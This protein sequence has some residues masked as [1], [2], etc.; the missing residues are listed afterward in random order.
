MN[1][2]STLLQSRTAILLFGL[3]A[4]GFGCHKSGGSDTPPTV[5][6]N[7]P[8]D[9]ATDVPINGRVSA[10]FSQEMD[11]ATLDG[12]TFT[13]T[14]GP[15]ANPVVGTVIYADSTATFWPSVHLDP[16]GSYDASITTGAEN[17]S[18]TPIQVL[19][20]WHFQ[21]GNT[22]EPG[23]PVPL[24]T[25]IN[26][27]ILAKSGI[28][29]VPNSNIT[30]DI[31]VSPAAATLITG[32]SLIMDASNTFSTSTQVTGEVRAADYSPPTPAV[33]TTA[34]SNM[35][36]AFTDAAGRAPDFTEL[37]AGD[38]GGLILPPGVYKWGTGVLIPTDVTLNGSATD[39][40][41][42]QIAQDLTMAND[43]Q[44]LLTGG[45]LPEN[46]F[47]QVTG[48]VDLGTTTQLN[49]IILCAT[50]INLQTNAAVNGRLMAQTA[51]TTDQCTVVAP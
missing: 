18:G 25:A 42:L 3:A 50:S 40:W 9:Q 22:T 27:A 13:L 19:V 4:T 8:I 7:I 1:S 10:T 28:S 41:I 39:I 30:G 16:N 29:S 43:K 44:V 21:T 33:M 11:P 32:F 5:L 34:I 51:V 24:G 47:W 31:G 49:G 26:F 45:A 14:S 12:T 2:I 15:L 35:E 37:G 17:A 23:R 48:L 38:I 46:I 6:S 36:T 20:T